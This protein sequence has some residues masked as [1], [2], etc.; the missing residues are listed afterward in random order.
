MQF[1]QFCKNKHIS[2]K[3]TCNSILFLKINEALQSYIFEI[4]YY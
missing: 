2:L 4:I 1:V 3:I